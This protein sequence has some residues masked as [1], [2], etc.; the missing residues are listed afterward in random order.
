[1]V[2]FLSIVTAL[3]LPALAVATIQ[4]N[5]VRDPYAQPERHHKRAA[6]LYHAAAVNLEILA[7]RSELPPMSTAGPFPIG[8]QRTVGCGRRSTSSASQ[9]THTTVAPGGD[10]HHPS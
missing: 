5:N 6:A 4:N 7:A 9:P 8:K 3:A 10:P 1:M 2:H